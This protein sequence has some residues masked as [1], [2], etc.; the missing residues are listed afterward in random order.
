M[1]HPGPKGTF[2]LGISGQDKSLFEI[3]CDRFKEVKEKYGTS[4]PWYIMTSKENNEETE[5]FFK[6]NDYFGYPKEDVRFFMQGELPMVDIKGK[7]LLDEDGLIKLAADGHGGLLTAMEKNNINKDMKERGMEWFVING[8]DNPLIGVLDPIF[9]G[10]TLEKQ[11]LSASKSTGKLNPEEKVGVF[12]KKN[13]N[14]SIV[15]YIEISEEMANA[16]DENGELLYG[17]SNIVCHLFNIN[18][19]EK[20][21]NKKLP[22]K[23][24][25]KKA[26]YLDENGNYQ[27]PTEPNSYKFEAFIFDAFEMLDDMVVFRVKREDEFAPIKNAC[28]NDSPETARK[29]YEEFHKRKGLNQ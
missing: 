11:L 1:G 26:S 23:A 2:M 25:F 19:F 9:I 17:D 24:A 5:E 7:I 22:Y 16:R 21:M 3:L 15:E 10:I 29:L 4:I 14:P 6:A 27:E 8:I 18:E 20:I 12:C 28:G 13:G